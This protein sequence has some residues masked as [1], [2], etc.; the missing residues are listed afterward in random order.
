MRMARTGRAPRA[1]GNS[2]PRG[3]RWMASVRSWQVMFGPSLYG[4]LVRGR[5]AQ[6]N[7]QEG[8]H[9][10][11]RILRRRFVVFEPTT[12]PARE[13]QNA[14]VEIVM[15]ARIDDQVDRRAAVVRLRNHLAAGSGRHH[16]VIC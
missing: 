12:R 10:R 6:M 8:A 1:M 3:A 9:L 5:P 16:V 4:R 2:T 11:F 15:S 14:K 7:R 13:G